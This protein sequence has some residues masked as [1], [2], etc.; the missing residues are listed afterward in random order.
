MNSKILFDFEKKKL[1]ITYK[2]KNFQM[3]DS[4]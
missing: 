1:K 2:T 3:F 4:N